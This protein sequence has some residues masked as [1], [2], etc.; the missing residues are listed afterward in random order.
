MARTRRRSRR[1]G[2]RRGKRSSVKKI[3]ARALA[4]QEETKIL[5]VLQTTV[6]MGGNQAYVYNPLYQI[7][8]GIG[9]G[10]RVGRKISNVSMRLSFRYTHR[11]EEALVFANVA[12]E[13]TIRLLVLSSRAIKTAGTA[14]NNLLANPTFMSQADIV[15]DASLGFGSIST[16]DKNK[17]TV[18]KD[19]TWK[20]H[21]YF[22][23]T[24][25]IG[26][27]P[28][29]GCVFKKNMRIRLPRSVVYR[30][31]TGSN[32]FSTTTE[33]YIVFMAGWEGSVGSD[34]VGE[35]HTQ[36]EIRYKDA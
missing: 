1:H 11:G 15:R 31:D 2:K 32:S 28:H 5:P 4:R 27:A 18:V 35:L 23:D 14:G 3:V 9:S 34:F 13:S 16:V 6:Q 33:T 25:A 22:D 20:C 19:K 12:E 8:Q 10:N 30:D 17:W 26:A 7:T 21:R 29:A 24:G 36:G